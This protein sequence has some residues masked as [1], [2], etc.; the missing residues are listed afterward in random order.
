ML[1]RDGKKNIRHVI[2]EARRWFSC[3]CLTTNGTFPWGDLELNRVWVSL[4]GPRDMHDRIRGAGV[5]QK[6]WQHILEHGQ[7]RTFISATINAEN[8]GSIPEMIELL[9]G[10]VE[11]VTIQ[12]HYPYDGLPDPLFV[13]HDERSRILDTLIVMKRDGYPLANS[14]LSLQDLKRIRWTC[15]DKLLANAEP[16]GTVLHGCYLK[17]RGPSVCGLCGFSAHNEMSL[18]FRGKLESIATGIRIFFSNSRERG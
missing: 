11:G 15:E 5:F 4:D 12:F 9:R 6:V 17:N 2:E 8:A 7:G 18:A 3:V 13:P 10:V 1:W 14:F 16:D